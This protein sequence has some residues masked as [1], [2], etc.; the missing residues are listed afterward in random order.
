MSY[1]QTLL[2]QTTATKQRQTRNKNTIAGLLAA[3]QQTAQPATGAAPVGGNAHF[4]GDGHDHRGGK[5]LDK[6]FD[7]RLQALIRDSGGK[8][9]IGS[10]YRSYDEQAR[11]YARYKAG[12]KGQAPAAPPGKS[13]HNHGLAADLKYAD[14][15]TKAWVHANAAKYGLYFPMSYEPW[16][17]EPLRT[18]RK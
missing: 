1:L 2:Q 13:N 15:A 12:V 14:K 7:S 6:D 17:I 9:S 8:V 5:G 3:V 4:A 16:H 10:G 11:L 18:K